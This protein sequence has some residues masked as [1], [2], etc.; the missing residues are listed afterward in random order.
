MDFEYRLLI[1]MRRL[2]FGDF[3]LRVVRP[4]AKRRTLSC[5]LAEEFVAGESLDDSIKAAVW[6]GEED[7]LLR[8]LELLASFFATFHRKTLRSAQPAVSR[9]CGDLREMLRELE[10]MKLGVSDKLEEI[11]HLCDKWEAS[12]FM[13]PDTACLVHGDATPT[14]FIFREGEGVTAIDLERV[15]VADPAYDLG[16]MVAEI[17]HHFALRLFRA[18]AAEKYIEHFFEIYASVFGAPVETFARVTRCNPFYMAL[19]EL[20]IARNPWLPPGHRRWLIEE[21]RRCLSS[22]QRRN[23]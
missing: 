11:S 18:S 5:L 4:I 1:Q 10:S 16:M 23:L 2:G 9:I 6:E 22:I 7:Q 17:K 15:Q 12:P 8:K 3:P 19:G 14:N 13:W 20:R 21:S